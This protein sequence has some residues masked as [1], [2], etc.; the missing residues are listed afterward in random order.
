MAQGNPLAAAPGVD[1]SAT[2]SLMRL[3]HKQKAKEY[4]IE[5]SSLKSYKVGLNPFFPMCVMYF[6]G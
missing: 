3:P 4:Y 2:T 6:N 5:H 1:G